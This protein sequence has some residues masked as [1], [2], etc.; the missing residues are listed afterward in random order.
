LIKP[1]LIEQKMNLAIAHHQMVSIGANKFLS[2]Y[3]RETPF[4][5]QMHSSVAYIVTFRL[6]RSFNEFA[7]TNAVMTTRRSVGR[8]WSI[9]LEEEN[10]IFM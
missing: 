1:I 9:F 3:S 2:R 7:A 10:I 4:Y 6:N 8:L 5:P